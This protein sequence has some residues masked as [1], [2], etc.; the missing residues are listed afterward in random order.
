MQP[1]D[2]RIIRGAA[3]VTAVA[4][5]LAV[6]VGALLAGV[7]G[8]VGTGLGVVVS[9]A[10][11]GSG[12]LA[13]GHVSHRW[14]ELLFGAAMLIYTTQIGLLLLLLFLLRDATFL[15]GEA[16]G[17]GVLV[18]LIAWLGGQIRANL[19]VK[20]PYVVTER[21]EDAAAANGNSR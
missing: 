19:K 4:A 13:L 21:D 12:Q 10:F 14:P 15:H 7:D 18:G 2:S 9:A 16:F 5:A 20:T 8:A 17:A 1:N 3:V 11:F 6:V